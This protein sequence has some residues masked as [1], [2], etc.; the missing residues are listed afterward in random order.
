MVVVVRITMTHWSGAM[1]GCGRHVAAFGIRAEAK[2][3]MN[4]IEELD[5]RIAALEALIDMRISCHHD[6]GPTP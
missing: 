5:C 3:R 6:R 2:M 4:I 1:G